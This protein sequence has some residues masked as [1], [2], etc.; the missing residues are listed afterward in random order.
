MKIVGNTVGTTL[1]KPDWNQTEPEKGGFIK[2]KPS[3]TDG[4]TFTP[5]VDAEGNLSWTNNHDLPNPNPINI[6]DK[7]F[8]SLAYFA[9]ISKNIC[10]KTS[11]I[12]R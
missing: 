7:H 4:A 9:I 6:N 1:P 12:T 8:I 2:N 11:C 3:A 10:A 5:S